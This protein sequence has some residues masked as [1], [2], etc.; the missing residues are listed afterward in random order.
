MSCLIWANFF[1]HFSKMC[2]CMNRLDD[3]A[4]GYFGVNVQK[5]F[6]KYILLYITSVQ[7]ML[8]VCIFF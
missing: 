6:Y 7:S 1:E 2:V 8:L 4:R 3:V 5:Q